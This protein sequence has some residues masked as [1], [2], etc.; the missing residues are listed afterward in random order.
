MTYATKNGKQIM[1]QRTIP[2]WEKILKLEINA[3]AADQTFVEGGLLQLGILAAHW[4]ELEVQT[5]LERDEWVIIN[6]N[7][8][9]DRHFVILCC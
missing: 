6:A 2:N 4:R 5:R 7:A 1:E 3:R 8:G 9:T